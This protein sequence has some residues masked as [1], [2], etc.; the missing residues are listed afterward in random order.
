MAPG[1][2]RVNCYRPPASIRCAAAN[3][4]IQDV[5]DRMDPR[6]NF[7]AAGVV[8][9]GLSAAP[10]FAD[11]CA[12]VTASMMATAKTPYKST[13]SRAGKDGKP[14]ISHMVQT[15]TAKYVET[16]GKWVTMP[17]SS[18][19][20]I[21]Q[22]GEMLKT[23]KMTCRLDGSQ[24]VNGQ[25][26]SIYLVHTENDGTVSDNKIWISAQNLPLKSEINVDGRQYVSTYDYSDVQPPAGAPPVEAE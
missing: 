26:A 14:L 19:D 18:Q 23:V 6:K 9:L 17:I 13:I 24:S 7:I 25:P 21:D 12:A 5:E 2:R 10:A 8:L 3:P 22:L 1:L 15:P 16:D 4:I 20:M 11:D